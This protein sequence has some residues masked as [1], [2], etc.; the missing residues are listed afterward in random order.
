MASSSSSVERIIRHYELAINGLKTAEMNLETRRT[1]HNLANENLI[2]ADLVAANAKSTAI[3]ANNVYA[4]N[5]ADLANPRFCR[6]PGY[7]EYQ[8]QLAN[9]ACAAQEIYDVAIKSRERFERHLK[10]AKTDLMKAIEEEKDAREIL[11]WTK[12][13]VDNL[14]SSFH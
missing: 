12:E 6:G 7:K 13:A 8:I 1:I 9:E 5:E 3:E 2:E 10:N 14:N 11:Q 4:K